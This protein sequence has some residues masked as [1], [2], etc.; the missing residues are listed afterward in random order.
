VSAAVD[1]AG[2]VVARTPGYASAA[3]A[4]RRDQRFGGGLLAGA[5][6]F[7]LFGALLPLALLVAVLL[8]YAETV[9][10]AG[11]ADAGEAV[12]IR[13][14]VLQS[15]AESSKLSAGTRW[16]VTAFAVIALVWA[17]MTAA[18]AVRAAHSLAWEGRVVRRGRSLQAGLVLIA[19][20]AGFAVIWA[21]V[22]WTRA[23][24]PLAGVIAAWAALV[25]FF[26]I[27]LGLAILLPHGR[28]PRRALVPGAILVA[29]G[30]Q[31]IHLGTVLFVADRVERASDT[32]GSLGVAFTMLFWLYVVSRVVVGSAMLNAA[33]W[34]RSLRSREE[35][36]P[37]AP[38][39]S[40]T[41]ASELP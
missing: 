29:V 22:G 18:R 32:Y 40:A 38:A 20:A 10:R 31:L 28:A 27:W 23:R 4:V 2:A 15:V 13:E 35:A 33:L 11:V 25:P 12:G 39:P 36:L 5:L 6:A 8:G 24:W 21:L 16:T 14:S 1:R 17:A 7:R 37:A 3:A 30:M 34:E 26:S 41:A 19:G 9:D